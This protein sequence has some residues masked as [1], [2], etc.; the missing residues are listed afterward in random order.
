MIMIMTVLAGTGVSRCE[1]YS[2]CMQ[3]RAF[4]KELK[5]ASG[6]HSFATM[7]LVVGNWA[8]LSKQTGADFSRAHEWI[9]KYVA[10]AMAEDFDNLRPEIV[11]VDYGIRS[12]TTH[13]PV[14]LI[15]FFI[16]Y[17]NF[18]EAWSHYRYS[19]DLDYC[20]TIKGD[21]VPGGCRFHAYYRAQ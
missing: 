12:R 21:K 20:G 9:I 2:S 14:D 16:G 13:S 8:Q 15:G 4:V 19:H 6:A 7:S 18:K 17:P 1:D 3:H 11:Y 10:N 5:T